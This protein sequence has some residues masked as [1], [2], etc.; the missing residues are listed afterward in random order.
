MWTG[1]QTLQSLQSGLTSV[2]A[3]LSRI[4]QEMNQITLDL[5]NNQQSQTRTLRQL[6]SIRLDEIKRGSLMDALDHTDRETLE[7]L[8]QRDKSLSA[9]DKS[10][11]EAEEEIQQRERAREEFAEQLENLAQEVIDAEHTVQ[12]KLEDDSAYQSQLE[13]ARKA[14]SIADEAEQKSELAKQDRIEKGKP[15][16]EDSLF[17]YL[18]NKHYS[19]PDYKANPLARALDGWVARLCNYEDNRVNYWTLLEIPKRLQEH[20]EN[21]RKSADMEADAVQELEKQALADAKVP[22]LQKKIDLAED[23]LVQHDKRIGQAE[24]SSIKLLNKRSA[25]VSGQ[26]DYTIKCINLLATVME[27]ND[28]FELGRAVHMTPSREDDALARELHELREEKEDLQKDIKESRKR[29]DIQLQRLKELEDV[30]HKFKQHRFDD[31]RS[32]FTNE[33][34]ITSVLSQFLKGMLSG[35]DLWSTMRRYQRHRDVGA[36]PDF[37]SGGLGKV[38]RRGGGNVWHRPGSRSG[39]GFRMPRNGGFSSRGRSGGFRTGGGF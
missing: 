8:E 7:V 6:A 9:L 13:R 33:A 2:K 26:D 32:G 12:S 4:D 24:E 16:E 31:L 35:A 17:L 27:R 37:G 34:L 22:D 20:V 36:W 39:G 23:E 38:K 19:T 28:V 29:Q 5:T 14:D 10:I 3:D 30:R 15:F 21:V 11:T 18:W 25:F 1:K